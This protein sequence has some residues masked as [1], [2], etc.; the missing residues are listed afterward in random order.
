MEPEHQPGGRSG[1]PNRPRRPGPPLLARRTSASAQARSAGGRRRRA[2]RRRLR[3]MAK[4][5]QRS[6]SQQ[7]AAPQPGQRVSEEGL[8]AG[9]VPAPGRAGQAPGVGPRRGR[10]AR[11]SSSKVATPPARAARSSGS[12]ST[13]TRVSPGSP[14]FPRRPSASAASGTSSATSRTCR[15]PAR[16]SCSTARWY[17]RAGVE[18]VMGFCTAEEYHRFLHQCPIFERMLVEDGILLRKYWFSRERRRAGGP[19]PVAPQGSDAAVEALA[20]GPRVDRPLGGLLAGEGPDDGPHR[21]RRGAAGTSSRAT[22][23]GARG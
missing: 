13:S 3:S 21:H 4:R 22:T 15:R 5:Q 9:A 19:V 7:S 14:R 8:R 2:R 12:R 17:N 1:A 16:S 18:K 20:D 23:S 6:A 10:T 11:R